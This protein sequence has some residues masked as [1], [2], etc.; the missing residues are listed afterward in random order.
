MNITRKPHIREMVF[1]PPVV[2]NP[3]KSIADAIM[4][5]VVK[6]T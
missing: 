6:K 3:W 2:L 5:A 4:V 1:T